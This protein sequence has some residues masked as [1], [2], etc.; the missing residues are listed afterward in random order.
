MTPPA[1]RRWPHH[2]VRAGLVAALGLALIGLAPAST[3]AEVQ[4]TTT[5]ASLVMGQTG[6]AVIVV[7]G[8]PGPGKPRAAVNAGTLT[9]VD[10]PSPGVLHLRYRLP[11]QRFPQ[12]LCLLLWREGSAVATAVRVPLS[13]ETRIPVQTRRNSLVHIRVG[14]QRFGPQ[15]SGPSGRLQMTVVVP[16]GVPD[17]EVQVV[18][19]AGL[20][21]QKSIV[22][23]AHPYNELTLAAIPVGTAEQPRYR[24]EVAAAVDR[25]RRVEATV[26]GQPL[27]LRADGDRWSGEWRPAASDRPRK[28][29]L[30]AWLPGNPASVQLV[31]IDL[32]VAARR[33][34]SAPTVRREPETAPTPP[35]T[36]PTTPPP[37]GRRVHLSLGVSAGLQANFGALLAPRVTAE[38]GLDHQL[39]LGRIG[40]R[41]LATFATASE[42]I[43]AGAGAQSGESTLVTVPLGL[44]LTYRLVEAPLSPYLLAAGVL[45]I[46]RTSSA[47]PGVPDRVRHDA[48]GGV[49]ALLGIEPRLGPGRIFVHAGYQWSRLDSIEVEG[50]IGGL[51]AE[52]GYRFEL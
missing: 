41:L 36:S 24:L 23:R 12:V 11:D 40:V 22:I 17:A 51:V 48:A 45:L 31:W 52:G 35:P 25:G 15:S 46:N 6:A 2:P 38:V 9:A 43:P 14:P 26:D 4:V 5:P 42:L 8:L 32:P 13:A 50:L 7:R 29:S 44:G 28:V 1:E 27:A 33:A 47:V 10:E 21:S 37:T 18:D 16:P 3:W 30:R 39:R 20:E 19:E 34:A 49:L